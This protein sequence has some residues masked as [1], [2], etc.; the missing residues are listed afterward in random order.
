MPIDPYAAVNAMIRAEVAR[1]SDEHDY[2]HEQ[3]DH[4]QSEG[5][6]CRSTGDDKAAAQRP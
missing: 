5:G 1:S 3:R 4:E 2:D 6:E